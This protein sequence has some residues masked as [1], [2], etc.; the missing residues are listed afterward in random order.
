MQSARAK[1][2]ITSDFESES[3]VLRRAVTQAE[4][5]RVISNSPIRGA[6]GAG[7]WGEAPK[8]RAWTSHRASGLG[9]RWSLVLNCPQCLGCWLCG[10]VTR[11]R[12][13][14]FGGTQRDLGSLEMVSVWGPG[15]PGEEELVGTGWNWLEPAVVGAASPR[16]SQSLRSEPAFRL[17]SAWTPRAPRPVRRGWARSSFRSRRGDFSR[18]RG[19][20]SGSSGTSVT[21]SAGLVQGCGLWGPRALLSPRGAPPFGEFP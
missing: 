15:R 8:G 10:V 18:G 19:G 11:S 21:R 17:D 3:R 5:G 4:G 6:A 1:P 7:G 20:R 13:G 2:G 16:S 14:S 12:R 9:E